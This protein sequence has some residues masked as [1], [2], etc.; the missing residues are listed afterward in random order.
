MPSI[1]HHILLNASSGAA[2][3][4]GVRPEQIVQRFLDSGYTVSIDAD[5]SRP[6]AQRLQ[7]ARTSPAAVLVAAGG[8]GTATALAQVAVE[9]G[10]ALAVL[11]L[12]TANLLGRDL[13][14]P[15]SL[16]DWFSQLPL[17]TPRQIDVGEVNARIFLHKVVIGAVPG[18]AAMREQIRGETALGATLAFLSHAI[19]RLSRLRRF[20]VEISNGGEHPHIERVQSIAVANNDYDEGPGKIFSRSRLDAGT[21]SLYLIRHLSL[22][23]ALRLAL[24]MLVGTW[25]ADDVVEVENVRAVVMR[26][27]QRRLRAMVDGEVEFLTTPLRFQ[28]RPLAL[29]VLAPPP[30]V[31]EVPEAAAAAEGV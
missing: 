19:R 2:L 15:L 25:K 30:A 10:R 3:K 21:L 6:F 24:R 9:T 26:T 17:M 1:S 18:I 28:V 11:P 23:D 5:T 4:T 31:A 29:T 13:G 7:T 12:G 14:L 8:D 20:A 27:R 16:D 22:G